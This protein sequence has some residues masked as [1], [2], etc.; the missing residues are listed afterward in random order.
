MLDQLQSKR[1]KLDEADLRDIIDHISTI[2]EAC[3]ITVAEGVADPT[4][5]VG[6]MDCIS[7]L[8]ARAKVL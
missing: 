7:K 4:T 5:T 3:A 6:L 2:S 1:E 8:S